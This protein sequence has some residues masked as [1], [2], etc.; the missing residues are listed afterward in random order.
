MSLHYIAPL[1]LSPRT[2]D[3]RLHDVE[4]KLDRVIVQLNELLTVTHRLAARLDEG[5]E[6]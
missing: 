1:P 5:F 3:D 6:L 4:V 2:A